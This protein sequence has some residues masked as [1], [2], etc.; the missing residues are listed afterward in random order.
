MG[1]KSKGQLTTY[2]EKEAYATRLL[3]D[4]NVT[5]ADVHRACES[6]I[7]DN[8]CLK[9]LLTGI[10]DGL[11][12]DAAAAF[13]GMTPLE[14]DEMCA[15]NRDFRFVV[16]LCKRIKASRRVAAIE[17]AMGSDWKAA[18]FLLETDT[19]TSEMYKGPERANHSKSAPS[20]NLSFNNVLDKAFA[21]AVQID[22]QADRADEDVAGEA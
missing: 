1:N 3:S 8:Q 22:G 6:F 13:A 7:G 10:M 15:A 12:A 17:S 4:H 21:E 14:L 9:I 11:S 18:K 5:A 16:N 19:D 20:V 2:E